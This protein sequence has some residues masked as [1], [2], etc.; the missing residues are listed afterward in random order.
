MKVLIVSGDSGGANQLFH[1]TLNYE[2]LKNY[3]KFYFLKEPAL[4]IFKKKLKIKNLDLN[5]TQ[6]KIKEFDLVICSNSNLGFE[7][8]IILES[9]KKNVETWVVFDH[10]V[11]YEERLDYKGKTLN[12]DKIIVFDKFAETLVKKKYNLRVELVKNFYLESIKSEF[13]SSCSSN[14][15]VYLAEPENCKNKFKKKEWNSLEF[16]LL[17]REVEYIKSSG[18]L[19]KNNIKKLRIRL[20]P[21]LNII[22]NFKSE[23]FEIESPDRPI[24]KSFAEAKI[25]IGKSSYALYISSQLKIKTFSISKGLYKKSLTIPSKLIKQI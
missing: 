7:K 22:K 11:R 25:C 10:W 21:S 24:E 23:E 16:E 1:F 6:K 19:G 2:N 15:A 9:L 5:S 20:H 12:P 8:V 3:S 17:M 18:V 4:S 13:G 14:T